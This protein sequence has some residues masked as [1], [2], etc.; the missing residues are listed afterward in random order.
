VAH[1]HYTLFGGSFFGLMAAVYFWWP[2]VTG[3]L[4]RERLG[5]LH[6]ALSVLG[7]NLTF[8]PMF[9]L[10]RDGMTRRVADYPA[11]AGWSTLNVVASAGALCIALSLLV[12][13]VNVIVSLRRPVPAG[14]NPWEA[15]TLEW[16]TRSPPPAA[17][18][19][20]PLPPIRSPH[21]LL[22]V[23]EGAA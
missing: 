2:K 4:L 17:N 12:F 19:A 15:H 21:P 6:F 18:F 16:F 23:R 3:V 22:D 20:D 9:F 10:G 8:F 5:R 11:D 7:A 13:A 1:F 14:D